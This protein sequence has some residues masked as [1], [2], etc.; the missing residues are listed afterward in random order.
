MS[1][2]LGSL[3]LIGFLVGCASASPPPS[4]PKPA[5][6]PAQHS[7]V[8]DT[9]TAEPS[10][11]VAAAEPE[12]F[13]A[14]PP[15][16]DGASP[17]VPP[18]EFARATCKGRFEALALTM[19]EKRSPWQRLYLKAEYA[20]AVN[21]HDKHFTAE[22]IVFGEE[23]IVL[24]DGSQSGRSGMQ[25]GS[26]DIDVLRW[27]RTCATVARELFVTTMMPEVKSPPISWRRLGGNMHGALLASKY[28]K[29]SHEREKEV[30]KGE[31]ASDPSPACE[32]ARRMLNDAITV[33]VRGGISLPV[34]DELPVW[35]TREQ[36]GD[37]G[38]AVALS[39]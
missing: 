17:C 20:E 28:V 24:R 9:E 22:P 35:A 32:K 39:D 16:C 27:D 12:L 10:A 25:V 5:A 23:V 31:R 14:P 30:C 6:P 18:L 1:R 2:P 8:A 15:G 26:S 36:L 34:A 11:P 21:A 13:A 33:A 29:M 37:G 4:Q 19:F 3:G 7:A 38:E